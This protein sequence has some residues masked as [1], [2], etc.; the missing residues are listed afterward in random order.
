M[1]NVLAEAVSLAEQLE[2]V[3][4][5]QRAAGAGELRE[6]LG[7]N[8]SP[9]KGDGQRVVEL[10]TQLGIQPGE[11]EEVLATVQELDQGDLLP[12][13]AGP[14]AIAFFDNDVVAPTKA[15]SAFARRQPA[16]EI[17]GGLVEGRVYNAAQMKALATL[18][19]KEVLVAQL[20][21][22]LQA[23]AASLVRV[24]NGPVQGLATAL[25]RISEQ[26]EAVGAA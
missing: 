21:G 25:T 19:P 8:N 3:A 17:K 7:R 20:L 2:A 22:M 1:S 16:L 14:T 23:P 26:K 18:P 10:M 5:E 13:L 9:R 24:L 11:L 12:L 4:R 15:L 6:I